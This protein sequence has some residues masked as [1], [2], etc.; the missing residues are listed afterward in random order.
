MTPVLG[1]ELKVDS[2]DWNTIQ[3]QTKEYARLAAAMGPQKPPR[4]SAD[5]WTKL[6]AAFAGSAKEL[7]EAAQAKNKDD[8]VA[9]QAELANSCKTCHSVHRPMRGGGPGGPG[10]GGFGPRGR[11]M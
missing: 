8:A 4:G 10:G 1:N 6:T 9:A 3:T 5:S 11:G 2:P 7:D